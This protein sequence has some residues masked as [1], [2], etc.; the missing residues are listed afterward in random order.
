MKEKKMKKN[1]R[2][3]LSI[4][5]SCTCVA[6]AVLTGCG[7]ANTEADS[8]D[9]Q[10]ESTSGKTQIAFWH[11]M[12]GANQE[13]L[14][15]LVADY[16]ASQDTYEVVAENQ[17]NYDESTGKFFNMANGD[18]S[19]AIIQIGEQN[20][21]SMVDSDMICSVT[22]LIKKYNFD[23]SDL[24]DQAVNFYTVD[25]NMYAMPFNSSCPVVYYN[26]DVFK[27]AGY[28]E[29]PTTFEELEEAAKKVAEVNTD[30]KPVGMFAYGYALDQMCTNMGSYIINNK[31]GRDGRATEVAY[32]DA[33]TEIFNWVA[34]LRDDGCLQSY[35]TD[36]EN[37][38]SAFTQAEIAMF[39]SSSA[40]ARN[41]INSS[42]FN[43]GIAYLPVPKGTE[44][45]GV[46][47]GGG[48]I[49]VAK[50]L[51]AEVESG[52]MDFL[53]YATSAEVQ[54]SWAGNTGYFP[55]SKAAYETD[56]LKAVYKELPQLEVA[57]QQL[58]ASKISDVTA[59]PLLSQ[60]PQLRSDIATALEAVCNGGDVDEAL[61]TAITSTNDAIATANEGV[62]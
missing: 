59:G 33:M 7:K 8:S 36:F 32:K 37:T 25:S 55:I 26:A 23:D 29:L 20:L 6:S 22:D 12:S 42:D 9:V 40:S 14:E 53:K 16:N 50:G 15:K 45:Q 58:L 54:A 44:A 31:N 19:A 62:K 21:Q 28:T 61:K 34:D 17:G 10:K 18:G 30:I 43:V 1:L 47:A 56:T 49:C 27:S 46:Y 2:K 5:L 39:I 11:S 24:L 3:Q 60:L 52:V 38:V 13:V 48:A 51:D 57:Q 41:I 4:V 35:G